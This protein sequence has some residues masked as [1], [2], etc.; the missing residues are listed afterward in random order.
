VRGEAAERVAAAGRTPQPVADRRVRTD[1]S[2]ARSRATEA[3]LAS[4]AGGRYRAAMLAARQGAVAALGDR[5]G[6]RPILDPVE[7]WTRLAHQ[8]P[9]F[10]EWASYFAALEGR[11]PLSGRQVDDLVRGIPLFLDEVDRHL[12]RCRRRRVGHAGTSRE[13]G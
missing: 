4:T 10:A 3:D 13:Q 11:P 12:L 1:L 2:R 5:P 9:R 8:V 7:L 6:G